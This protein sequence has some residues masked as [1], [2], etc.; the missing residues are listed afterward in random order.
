MSDA[1]EGAAVVERGGLVLVETGHPGFEAARDDLAPLAE[2][3]KAPDALH[4]YKLTPLS[5][6]NAAA[7]GIPGD[8]AVL[9]LRRHARLGVPPEV[10]SDVRD[11][12]RRYGLV[13]LQPGLTSDRVGIACTDPAALAVLR[14]D[15][16]VASLLVPGTVGRLEV[17]ARERGRLKQALVRLGYPAVDRVG[18]ARFAPLSLSLR[19]TT[20]LRPYQRA[21][22]ES[23]FAGGSPQ[24]PDGGS[25]IVCL[26]CG[27]GKTLVGLA[28]IARLGAEALVITSGTVAARQWVR[29]A[30]ERTTLRP[31]QVGEYTG[32]KKQV[33]PLT[34]TTYSLLATRPRG[35]REGDPPPH[36]E[37]LSRSGFGLIVY[38]EVHLL[39]A[40]VFRATAE[41]QAKRRLGLTATLVREDGRETDVFALLG[42]KRAEV[43]WKALEAQRYLAEARCV[44][45]EVPLA[46]SLRDRYAFAALAEMF[47]I[48]ATNPR[49]DEVALALVER[50]RGDR[51]LVI[52]TYLDQLGRLAETLGAPLITGST[53]EPERD[54]LYGAFRRGEL[55][56]LLVSKV[57]NFAIDLPDANV[58]IEVSGTYGSRQEEA[59]RLGRV[60]R[61][62]SDGSGAVFYALTT[63][64]TR[65]EDTAARRQRFLLEQGYRYEKVSSAA[66]LAGGSVLA[67]APILAPR[68]AP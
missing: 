2:L 23:F 67:G 33:R 39:P 55:R 25:G 4:T 31:D 44:E 1:G 19:E 24:S 7:L 51:V 59:Q 36:L 10:E 6:W 37:L 28:A 66:V 45:V 54:R 34:V 57:A 38:D 60:L 13:V 46:P 26:P 41:I 27:A 9:R 48:A 12:G 15:A 17:P 5:L 49:K 32:S 53:P 52:G 63:K 56:V 42:P 40:P 65:E 64:D 14:G 50:H 68:P 47:H 18:Y 3:V 16:E 35:A 21:A 8:E 11:W 43:G 29:E 22:V 61:P 30:V 58:A 20:V 62:K